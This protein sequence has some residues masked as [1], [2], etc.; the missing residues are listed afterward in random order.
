MNEMEVNG[1]D[2]KCYVWFRDM[3][4]ATSTKSLVVQLD[5][6]PNDTSKG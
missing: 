5:P 3:K 2:V 6:R 4:Y 1:K